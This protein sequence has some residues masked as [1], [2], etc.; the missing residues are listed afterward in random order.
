[1]NFDGGETQ[2]FHTTPEAI[3]RFWLTWELCQTRSC[4]P[5]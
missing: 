1:L 4:E 3:Q 5:V 2:P